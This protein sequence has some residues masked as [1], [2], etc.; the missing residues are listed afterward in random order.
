MGPRARSQRATEA[1]SSAITQPHITT[2]NVFSSNKYAALS[3]RAACCERA[4]AS[5]RH[6]A[7]ECRI[8]LYIILWQTP[9]FLCGSKRW[10]TPSNN[11]RTSLPVN[12]QPNARSRFSCVSD[13]SHTEAPAGEGAGGGRRTKENRET[14]CGLQSCSQISVPWIHMIT[15]W[16]GIGTFGR[17]VIPSSASAAS[18]SSSCCL[19]LLAAAPP[20]TIPL[21]FCD[22]LHT[23]STAH[24]CASGWDR[25]STRG[26]MGKEGGAQLWF[27]CTCCCCTWRRAGA[28]QA[29]ATYPYGDQQGEMGVARQ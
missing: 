2:C 11:S 9:Q 14:P 21:M 8:L 27:M 13:M 29:E 4:R 5:M 3:A 19:C 7:Q 20:L 23:D 25:V 15:H 12:P 26:C 28:G 17:A 18:S 22:A 24:A 16:S 1:F 6:A 10:P